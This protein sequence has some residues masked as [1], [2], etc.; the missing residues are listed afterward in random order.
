MERLLHY[1]S[2]FLSISI[3]NTRHFPPFFSSL[4]SITPVIITP[5]PS[6]PL[7]SLES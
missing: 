4:S 7:K 2:S 3:S 1:I 5:I 6:K